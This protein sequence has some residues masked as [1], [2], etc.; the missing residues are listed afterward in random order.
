MGLG[1]IFLMNSPFSRIESEL[2]GRKDIVAAIDPSPSS[3]MV[4]RD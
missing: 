2:N 4:S 1:L 3:C